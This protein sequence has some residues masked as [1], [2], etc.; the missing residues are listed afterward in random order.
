MKILATL[1][2]ANRLA[3]V[4]DLDS[5]ESTHVI[6]TRPEFFDAN[7]IGRAACRPFGITW[8]S[9]ELFI[10]NN[11]QLLVFDHE[12]RFLR[13]FGAL[14]QINMHQIAFWRDKVWAVSPWTNSIIGV[15][16]GISGPAV[17][18][19]LTNSRV[20]AYTERDGREGDDK[21]HFNS[22]L[23]ADGH[24]F[25]GAHAFGGSS[26]IIQYHASSLRLEDVHRDV[27][28]A[29]HGL[30]RYQDELFWISTKTCEIRSDAGY[31]LRLRRP[32]Y[33]RG[34]A[35]TKQHF[36]VATSEVLARGE[37][38]AGDSWI[39]VI[40]RERGTLARE[41]HLR[42][43]GG[44]NDLRLLDRYDYAHRTHPLLGLCSPRR[45]N[46]AG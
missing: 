13:I 10:V 45:Q 2:D 19:D 21:C 28:S 14:L 46:G 9:R 41:V 6:D 8:N 36:V 30:A 1:S 34:F 29:I 15:P 38:H 23:W 42:A 44:I 24:L 37:R 32:G 40:D 5:G 39:Q 18:L 33:A 17:E 16:P 11:R 25:V 20:R 7:V 31:R 12:F 22:L 43:T 35:M 3:L 27:G 4:V 26:F